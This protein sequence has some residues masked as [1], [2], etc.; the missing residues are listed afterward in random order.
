MKLFVRF[1]SSPLLGGEAVGKLACELGLSDL[2]AIFLWLAAILTLLAILFIIGA[3]I[4]YWREILF[5]LLCIT[6]KTFEVSKKVINV[7]LLV[8]GLI[9][10]GIDYVVE[11]QSMPKKRPVYKVK[12][13]CK[14]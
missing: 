13:R 14:V 2:G 3:V 9:I 8:L 5:A 1:I 12:K 7:I 11:A 10:L 6:W 4:T